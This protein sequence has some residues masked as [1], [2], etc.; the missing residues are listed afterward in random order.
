MV[1]AH[2]HSNVQPGLFGAPMFEHDFDDQILDPLHNAELG[3]PKAPWKYGVLNN[4]SDDGRDQTS[5]K[6]REWKHPLDCRRKETGRVRQDKWFTGAAWRTFCSAERGSPGGPRAIAHIVLIL[7]EDMSLNGVT[8]DE[9]GRVIQPLP[10]L[11]TQ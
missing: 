4:A 6:L 7:A 5:A 9:H 3:L 10:V 11:K 1:H 8:V 2:A